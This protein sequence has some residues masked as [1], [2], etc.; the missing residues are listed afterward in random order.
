MQWSCQDSIIIIIFEAGR[1]KIFLNSNTIF[2]KN[3]I[4][5]K[6]SDLLTGSI[7]NFSSVSPIYRKFL[8][9]SFKRTVSRN[10]YLFWRSK[11]FRLY[12][13]CMRW[14]FSRS[15]KN[16]S[17]P[18]TVYNFYHFLFASLKSLTNFEM[19]TETLLRIPFSVI[20][21]FSPMPTSHWLKRKE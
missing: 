5:L 11:H 15:F 19:L 2:Y 20:G 3:G 13:L 8:V 17:L 10:G 4:I 16:F 21:Q 14:W 7:V 18:C 9:T 6:G 12:F 1:D